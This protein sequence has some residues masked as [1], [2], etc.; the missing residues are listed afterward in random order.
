VIYYYILL[1]L[2][3]ICFLSFFCLLGLLFASLFR[4][5]A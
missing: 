4:I 1:N 5:I 2:P 3:F